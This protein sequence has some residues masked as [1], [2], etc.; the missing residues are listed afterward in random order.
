M[1]PVEVSQLLVTL[2]KVVVMAPDH[3]EVVEVECG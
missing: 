2:L 1:M 3:H